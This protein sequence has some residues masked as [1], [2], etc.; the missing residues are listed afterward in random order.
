MV[1]PSQARPDRLN[2]PLKAY[3]PSAGLGVF[4]RSDAILPSYARQIADGISVLRLH[5]LVRCIGPAKY[6]QAGGYDGSVRPPRW[7]VGNL[8]GGQ[9]A[10]ISPVI[11]QTLGWLAADSYRDVLSYPIHLISKT[12]EI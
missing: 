9:A 1:V 10:L 12:A 11:L 8:F 3:L 7:N 5:L 4:L 6:P 2:R